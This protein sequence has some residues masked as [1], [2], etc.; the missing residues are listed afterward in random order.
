MCSESFNEINKSPPPQVIINSINF[1]LDNL[2][3][4]NLI[5]IFNFKQ[6]FYDHP[7]YILRIIPNISFIIN[8]IKKLSK[9]NFYHIIRRTL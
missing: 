6:F 8:D 5:D 4:K 9:Q 2:L 7:V 1:T 3:Q